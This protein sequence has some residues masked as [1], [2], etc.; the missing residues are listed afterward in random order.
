MA[1][2]VVA[3]DG[4][5]G[6]GKSTLARRLALALDLPYVNTG[7]MYR[8]LTLEAIR[9]GVEPDDEHGLRGL[10]TTIRFDLDLDLRPPELR[11]EGSAPDPALVSPEV[12]AL[13]SRV[14]RHPAVRELMRDEQR[15]L[16][17]GGAV[18]E[19]RDIGSV[20]FPDALLRVVLLARADRRAA[21]R[22]A[23]REEAAV[24]KVA[25]AIGT[26]DALDARNVPALEADL[27]VDST[28]LGPD[29]VFRVVLDQVRRR[30][31]RPR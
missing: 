7:L 28:D 19:G 8:A 17:E 30:I 20:V 2:P 14:A 1:Q 10:A 27:E 4:P 26:R 3:I 16:G 25:E 12:E 23:E 22:A 15:R 5:A 21:R 13:V 18:M 6:S 11:I 24:P 31:G 9:R 29:E